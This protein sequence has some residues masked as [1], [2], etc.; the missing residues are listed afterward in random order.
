M[1]NR[2]AKFRSGTQI[3]LVIFVQYFDAEVYKMAFLLT[4]YYFW[5]LNGKSL[6]KIKNA[7]IFEI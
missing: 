3:C 2:V 5:Y 4:L 1:K 7:A 6:K